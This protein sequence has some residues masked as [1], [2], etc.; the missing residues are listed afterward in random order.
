MKAETQTVYGVYSTDG[1]TTSKNALAYYPIHAA[2]AGSPEAK[3][4]RGYSHIGREEIIKFDE[5]IYIFEQRISKQKIVGDTFPAYSPVDCYQDYSYENGCDKT[6][7]YVGLACLGKALDDGRPAN[8][9]KKAII[10][11]GEGN[12]FLLKQKEPIT[13]NKFLMSH[14]LAVAHAKSKLTEEEKKLLGL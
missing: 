14:E 9:R 13:V 5:L 3:Q 1:Y 6:I 11:D 12:Y 10:A 8:I 7:Y 2:A 4:L